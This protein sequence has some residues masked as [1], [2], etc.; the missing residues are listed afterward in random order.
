MTETLPQGDLRLTH[1]HSGPGV[2]AREYTIRARRFHESRQFAERALRDFG[3]MDAFESRPPKERERCL[4]WIAGA[5]GERE[6]EDRVSR[7]LDSLAF[8][9][10]LPQ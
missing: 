2:I 6:E 7:V 1:I 4:R 8:E 5:A 3:L 10:A 9:K